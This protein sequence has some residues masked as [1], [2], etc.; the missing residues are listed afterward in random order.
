MVKFTRTSIGLEGSA[1]FYLALTGVDDANVESSLGTA[2][3]VAGLADQLVEAGTVNSPITIS[4]NLS[5]IIPETTPTDIK[6]THDVKF[7]EIFNNSATA[8]LYVE[9]TGFKASVERSMPVLPKV[10]YTVF[11]NLSKDMGVSMIAAGGSVDTRIV[12][13]Y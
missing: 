13:H 4:E 7:L 1:S 6:F 10:Y 8:V 11:R 3:L 5:R 2:R 12:V 9:V